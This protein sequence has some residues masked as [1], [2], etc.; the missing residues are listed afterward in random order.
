[1]V[2]WESTMHLPMTVI[3]L[4]AA[5]VGHVALAVWLFNRL[6]ALGWPRPLVKSLE[7][8]LLLVAL[9]VL[10]LIITSPLGHSTI[11]RGHSLLSGYQALCWLASVLVIPLWILPKLLERTP[12]SLLSNDTTLIDIAERVG[13]RPLHGK[14]RMLAHVP[15]NQILDLAVQ[16]KTLHLPNLPQ[17]LDGLRIAHLSDL[18]MTGQ[19]GSEFYD[20]VVEE[21]NALAP[22][23]V[24]ITGDILEKESC[25]PW[26]QPTLGR[27]QARHGK[28]FI[29]GNHEQRLPDV[30]PLRRALVE[31]GLVDLGSKT[32]TLMI[33]GTEILL[34]G[35]ERPWFGAAPELPTL[36]PEPSFRILLSHTPDNLFWAKS[37]GFNLVLAGHTHGGQIRLPRLGAIIAPSFHGSRY[38]G[39]L[40]F[41]PPTLMHVSRGL[42]GIHPLRLN[43]RPELALLILKR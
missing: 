38:A 35:N 6:H 8:A 2:G 5:C 17:P 33:D 29:L 11:G 20:C 12:A 9:V 36:N 37:N 27:L 3:S 24:V 31:A 25:L 4:S 23:I 13:F 40:Y 22:D 41:E 21:T 7:K 39:G 32:Q 26:I 16:Q 1:M 28:F 19:L 43:C 30:T 34:A 14:A 42:A 18:H 10:F 15:G